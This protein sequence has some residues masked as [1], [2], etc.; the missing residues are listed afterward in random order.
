MKKLAIGAVAVV[1]LI[2]TPVLAADLN[3]P[4]YKAPPPAP[5]APVYTWTGW[6]VGLNAG[7]IGSDDNVNTNAVV[8]SFSSDPTTATTLAAAAT[9]QLTDRASGFL[10]GGQVGYN[11]QFASNLLA[12]FEADIQGSSLRGTSNTS[13]SVLTNLDVVPNGGNWNTTTAVSSHLNYLGTVRAR[14]GVIVWPTLLMYGTG[15]FAYGGVSSNT[16]MG[17]NATV[18]AT[19]APGQGEPVGSPVVGV[20]PGFTSGSFSGT[21]TGWTAGAGLEWMFLPNWSAK[22]EY[23]HYDLGSATYGTGGYSVAVG[24]TDLPGD[25]IAAISTSTT[26]QFRGD[27]VRVGL[28]YLFR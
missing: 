28:N 15:G 18:N 23:L 9:N 16:S 5:P 11:Y 3:K 24:P 7:W 27:I 26:E 20:A 21:R 13:N 19:G 12:G 17:I 22:L 1:A 6:Y 4:V 14:V 25:G 2:G 8:T 10:G